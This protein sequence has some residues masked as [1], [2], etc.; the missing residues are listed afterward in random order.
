MILTKCLEWAAYNF[1]K[2]DFKVLHLEK[3]QQ[4]QSN[5][6]INEEYIVKLSWYSSE[7][8]THIPIYIHIDIQ[9]NW[10]RY[11]NF[12]LNTNAN[13]FVQIYNF[14]LVYY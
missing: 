2:Y 12:W 4:Y 6:I 10:F 14:S 8:I 3:N 11:S 9:I 1:T 5:N 7:Y 13:I